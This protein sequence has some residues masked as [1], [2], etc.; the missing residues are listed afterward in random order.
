MDTRA[1]LD[2]HVQAFLA[3]DIEAI[4]DD[5]ADDAVFIVGASVARG[6]DGLRAVYENL[7]SGIFA[8]GTFDFTLDVTTVEGEVGYI[9]WH[10]SGA[11]VEV[12]TGSDTYVVRDGKIAIQTVAADIRPK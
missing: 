12:P 1:V 2:H 9:T 8:P 11:H 3:G 10:A 4:L 5:Y 6:R 7:L